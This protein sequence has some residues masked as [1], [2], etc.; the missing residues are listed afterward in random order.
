MLLLCSDGVSD[1][2]KPEELM[3]IV[4]PDNLEESVKYIVN[5]AKTGRSVK[6]TRS[7]YDD[8]TI[9]IYKH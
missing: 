5:L 9:M 2:V 7:Q 8:I 4:N 3:E 6:E 1:Y